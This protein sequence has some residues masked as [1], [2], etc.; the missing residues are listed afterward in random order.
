MSAPHNSDG[1]RAQL[2]RVR[3]RFTR[4]A[5]AFSGFVLRHRAAEAERAVALAAPRG[6]ERA[7]DLACGPGTFAR[8]FAPRVRWLC[9]LD[10][11]LAM[12]AVARQTAADAK[13][14]NLFFAC[15]NAFALPFADKSFDLAVCGY[16]FH[17][18]TEPQAASR[19]LARV[20]RPGGRLV[21][22]D[23]VVPDDSAKAEASNGIERVRDASHTRTFAPRELAALLEANGFRVLSR[24]R[25]QLPRSFDN[26]MSVAGW[27]R[28]D[29]AYEETRRLME[30]SISEDKTGFFPRYGEAGSDAAPDIEFMQ[31]SMYFVAEKM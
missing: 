2:D 14:G 8:A 23:M 30:A 27:K 18:M 20:L 15:G 16:S 19:E 3:D 17:H 11:T 13:L 22:L 6:D 12:L 29:A 24:E 9:G 25:Q 1:D 10:L 28:G 5:G 4:T 7:L 21:L 26:W 31:S